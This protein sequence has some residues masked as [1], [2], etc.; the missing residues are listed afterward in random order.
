MKI[1]IPDRI[2]TKLR[3]IICE[4]Q[5]HKCYETAYNQLTAD[6]NIVKKSWS[7]DFRFKDHVCLIL[8]FI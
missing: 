3:D 5:R 6:T 4:F 7:S 8:I 2:R 1:R